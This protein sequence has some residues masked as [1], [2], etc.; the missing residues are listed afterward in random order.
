MDH[1]AQEDL[2]R[3]VAPLVEA[4]NRGEADEVLPTIERRLVE[5]GGG[6]MRKAP[7]AMHFAHGVALL[8][9]DDAAAALGATDDM[10]H[11]AQRD[12]AEG[13]RACALAMRAAFQ[14]MRAQDNP[15]EYDLDSVLADL[16]AAEVALDRSKEG[17]YVA[18]CGHSAIFVSY[19]SLR[20]YELALP[21]AEAAYE[22]SIALVDREDAG[23]ISELL[24]I[25]TLHLQWALELIRVELA[26]EAREHRARAHDA[27]SLALDRLTDAQEQAWTGPCSLLQAM[28]RPDDADPAEM[29]SDI[30]RLLPQVALG[31]PHSGL[32]AA[33]PFLAGALVRLGHRDQAMEVVERALAEVRVTDR[34]SPTYL[35]LAHT[36]AFLLAQSS[37]AARTAMEYGDALAAA[38]WRQRQ[39]TLDSAET[40]RAYAQL[41][42]DH[43][44]VTLVAETDA[45]TGVSNRR[46]LDRALESL[47]KTEDPGRMVAV[48]F[49]DVDEFKQVNDSFGHVVGDTMLQGVAQA[50]A[51]NSR[52]DDVVARIGGDEFAVLLPGATTEI[53]ERAARRIIAAVRDTPSLPTVS[54]GGAA[55][56]AVDVKATV[57]RADDAMYV[58]KRGGRNQHYV[59][60]HVTSSPAT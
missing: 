31:D 17:G 4:A 38:S 7:A 24:N 5:L 55:G 45:L 15:S 37:E 48:L 47:A 30:Q 23:P 26:A 6:V 44:Q 22:I 41:R 3:E 57:T 52:G 53:A 58:A 28:A 2:I 46:A 16:A 18:E 59:A 27:C 34:E 33:A 12:G 42:A 13:W 50:I 29:A 1:A 8:M 36:R 19:F 10:L 14:I 49:I 56:P 60:P 21:H 35:S 39:R 54:I 20:L 32:L 25:A 11:A 40:M 51:S 9:N 43:E